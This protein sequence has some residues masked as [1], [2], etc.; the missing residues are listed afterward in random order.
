MEDSLRTPSRLGARCAATSETETKP[1]EE[2]ETDI[3][4]SA[5]Y[6]VLQREV[7][8]LRSACQEKDQDIKDKDSTIKV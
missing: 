2:T 4:S 8:S 1:P 7:I 3:V 6:D 5:L